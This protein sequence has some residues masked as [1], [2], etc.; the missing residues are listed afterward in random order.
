[1]NTEPVTAAPARPPGW[2]LLIAMTA[3]ALAAC[4]DAAQPIAERESAD[5]DAV[6]A[7]A[8]IAHDATTAEAGISGPVDAA[9]EAD[10]QV[11][12]RVDGA[13][14]PPVSIE[15]APLTVLDLQD[16]VPTD[17]GTWTL[18]RRPEGSVAS[19]V[20]EGSPWDF[21][22]PDDPTTAQAHFLVDY[23]GQFVLRKEGPTESV[24]LNV[25]A[26]PMADLLVALSWTTPA[27]P[28]PSDRIGTDV[29]LFVRHERGRDG[30]ELN[31]QWLCS[32]RNAN[33]LWSDGA[34]SAAL[35]LDSHAGS[36]PE[37]I[38]IASPPRG[39]EYDVAAYYSRP[40]S[41]FGGDI[42]V[43]AASIVTVAVF[44][45]GDTAPA[46]RF[47]AQMDGYGG[48]WFA[49]I[50]VDATT[51]EVRVRDVNRPFDWAD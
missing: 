43:Q 7:D 36:L 27:D 33:P 48:I 18:L 17:Q 47:T 4:V 12:A 25:E 35:I 50:A 23:P 44:V 28:D 9:V 51:G 34:E 32:W 21:G 11:D 19:V 2:P 42:A 14:S 40:N 20:Y 41:T 24:T 10:G 3:T 13:A 26:I 8:E 46:A 6:I 49:T 1:M 39:L 37:F 16:F 15:V 29:D 5:P 22:P 30:W 31:S 38:R 45:G